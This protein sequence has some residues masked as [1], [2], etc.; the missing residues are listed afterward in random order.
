MDKVA[1]RWKDVGE[2]EKVWIKLQGGG[3]M[4]ERL[5]KIA[6]SCGGGRAGRRY[7]GTVFFLIHERDFSS[8]YHII[9]KKNEHS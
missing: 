5:K 4:W 6:N 1:R 8:T 7:R 2:V 3:K 9:L